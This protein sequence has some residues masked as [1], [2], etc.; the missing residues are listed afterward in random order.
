M[1][2]WG[3]FALAMLCGCCI[4]SA[5]ASKPYVF[6]R[7]DNSSG[8]TPYAIVTA[9][10]NSDGKLDM[11][12]ANYSDNTVSVFLG[13]PDGTFDRN[14]DY[15]VGVEPD[16]LA[17]GD[18]NGDGRPDLA[19]TN[20]NCNNACGA[21]SVSILLNKG[22]GTFWPPVPYMTDTDP[23]SVVTGDFN[24]DGRLDIA[25]S[26]AISSV[27]RVPG[28]V[29]IYLNN[30]DGTFRLSGKYSAGPAAGQ[31]TT[32]VLAGDSKASVAVTN[33]VSISGLNA[34]SILRNNGD[35]TLAFPVFYDTG[36][37]PLSVASADFNQDGIADLAVVN[38]ADNTISIL[39]GKS[40]GTFAG[41]VDYPTEFGPNRLAVADLNHDGRADLV[42][43]ART[44]DTGGG[45]IS[46]LLSKGDGTFQTTVS[47]I[48]GNNPFSLVTGDFNHDGKL[49][50]AF[51]NGD[52]DRFS[53]LLG[54][55]D[56]T[57]PSYAAYPVGFEPVAMAAAD[58]NGDSWL[59]L[60]VADYGS[61]MVS[62]L[63]GT[64][65]GRLV[66]QGT[67]RV[68]ANPSGIA[69]VD[70]DQDGKPDIVVSNSA[71]NTIS[72][73]YNGGG[74]FTSTA[75]IPV[76]T[77]PGGIAVADFNGDHI[78]DLAVTNTGDNTVSILFNLGNKQF[79]TSR[80]Y[81]TGP[82]PT[83]VVAADLNGDGKADLAIANYNSPL[84]EN[85][86]G[87]IS[88]LLN[89]GDGTFLDKVDYQTAHNPTALVVG[90]FNG[91]GKLD[92]AAAANLDRVGIVS[93]FLGNGDGTL[94]HAADYRE[95]F[96]IA[97]LAAADFNGDGKCDLAVVSS[98]SNT[99][100]IMKGVG[101]G[102]FQMQGTFGTIG[103]PIAVLAGNFSAKPGAAKL[104][105]LVVANFGRAAL[106]LFLNTPSQ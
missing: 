43:S 38:G 73:L 8:R 52:V 35:G 89:R 31:L 99:V 2:P 48:T 94:Q 87:F 51:T 76:G 49:D 79:R 77:S 63:F 61:D 16:A 74:V 91:D 101:D 55:G 40:N 11:A 93:V 64:W 28:E 57:F 82:G 69:I 56:G 92:L 53:V 19:V 6:G 4:Q 97:S 104:A 32:V 103:S 44:A 24:G 27:Q 78:P 39:L 80:P 47:F 67:Y 75:R 17:V 9:D 34:V 68:G 20:Q 13:K 50:V 59:D 5:Y 22:D 36:K 23:V 65:D 60:V 102:S 98:L 96:G 37:G 45:A 3:V 84:R 70:L 100:F 85:D 12:V 105:D 54:N 46:I 21:T 86:P 66:M 72:I 95:G 33:F 81:L 7:A 26:N 42:V 41:K 58:L 18:F 62:V 71:D 106:S 83:S 29:S 10:F 25:V 30:G 15:V 90:D 1:R 88:V 14:A